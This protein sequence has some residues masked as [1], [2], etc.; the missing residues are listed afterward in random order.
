MR[1]SLEPR[2]RKYVQGYG[3]LLFPGKIGNKYGET[4]MDSATKTGIDAA[5]T[6]FKGVVQKTA[7]ATGDLIGRK[8]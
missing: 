3:F 7:E 2:K 8:K 5:K 1:Y 6:A 4:L